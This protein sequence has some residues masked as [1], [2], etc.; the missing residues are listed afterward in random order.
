MSL[1]ERRTFG[2]KVLTY[3]FFCVPSAYRI[4]L[5]PD[6]DDATFTGRVEI[7]IDVHES[8]KALT[9]HALNLTLSVA[10]IRAGERTYHSSNPVHDE[11]YE[12]ATFLFADNLP[13]GPATLEIAYTGQLNDLLVGFYRSTFTDAEGAVHT[14]ATTQ[15]EH[16]DAR[17]AFPCWD[18]PSFKAT[19]Q[20]NLVVP[21][22]LAAYSNSPEIASSDLGNG[23]R[24]VSFAPTMKMSTYLV[25]FVVGPFEETAPREDEHRAVALPVPD[26][27]VRVAARVR[28]DD[29]RL[30]HL[31]EASVVGVAPDRLEIRL[32]SAA[33]P[34]KIAVELLDPFMPGDIQRELYWT[35]H[36]L[37]DERESRKGF[38]IG[39]GKSAARN[40]RRF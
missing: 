15:F 17:R 39:P 19:Y 20:V 9:L 22:D 40:R 32:V 10:T 35:F 6:L 13:A 29:D 37:T 27:P 24:S 26:L 38:Q 14:I 33:A 23:Q 30:A 7:D 21:N 12:T 4:F 16:S 11:T 1:S 28:L 2:P 18:E 3:E 34:Q 25:A 36:M 8:L 5:T 31:P